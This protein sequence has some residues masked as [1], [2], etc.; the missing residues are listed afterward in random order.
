MNLIKTAKTLRLIVSHEARILLADRTLPLVCGLLSLMIGYG[1][2]T[3]ILQARTHDYMASKVLERQETAQRSNIE[4]LRQV[5]AGIAKP[6]PFSNPANPANVGGGTAARYALMPTAPLAPLAIG[7]SDMIPD[8]YRITY[9]SKVSFLYDS[10]NENPWKLLSG[11]FDLAFVLVFLLPLMIFGLSYNLLSA[12]REQG[13]LRLLCSQPLTLATVL[14][15]KVILRAAAL[16]SCAVLIPIAILL[17]AR[18]E[19][20]NAEQSTLILS[21]GAL[22]VAYTMFWFAIAVLVNTIGRSSSANALCL[23]AIWTTLVLIAP[24]LLD[25][26]VSW[27]RPAPSRTELA[28]QT[29]IATAETLKRYEELFSTDYRYTTDPDVLVVK[30]GHIEIPARMRGFFLEGRDIDRALDELIIRF[31]QQLAAQ[32]RLVNALS[33]VSPAVL[34]YEGITSVAG[35]GTHRFAAFKQ[36]V[37]S[38]H[39]DWRAYFNPRIAAGAAM[40]QGDLESLPRWKWTELP[41]DE[42]RAD[43]WWRTIL[44]FVLAVLFSG[45]A[46]IRLHQYSVA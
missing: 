19:I 2:F 45:I 6:E 25:L 36:Q 29:R 33:F 42:T 38:F 24:V 21:W 22:V 34:V 16:L 39:N 31:D 41:A 9:R 30:D 44:M 18:P 13:T 20:R 15:G 46:L 23:V 10:E 11:H 17:L 28:T 12:E 3:G 32:Q 43:V 14:A 35:N 7:Q 5:L 4:L 27:A 8:Y 37:E 40:T 1:V 26:G